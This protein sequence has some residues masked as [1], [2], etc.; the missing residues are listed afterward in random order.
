VS[1]SAQVEAQ[2]QARAHSYARIPGEAAA[3][4]PVER[5]ME[6]ICAGVEVGP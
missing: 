1:T 5:A 3:R 4:I 2:W 6:L